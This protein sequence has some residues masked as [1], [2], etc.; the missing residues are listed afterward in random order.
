[1]WNVLRENEQWWAGSFLSRQVR[2]GSS[3]RLWVLDTYLHHH[4][5][6]T[7]LCNRKE[8]STY[9][10]ALDGNFHIQQMGI[11]LDFMK[12]PLKRLRE[13]S[14]FPFQM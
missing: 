4:G 9:S 2:L 8:I 14:H 7:K 11:R 12:A 5:A 6:T 13:Q 10:K 1:M 3:A